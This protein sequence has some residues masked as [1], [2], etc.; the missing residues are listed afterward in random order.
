MDTLMSILHL[1]SLMI[2]NMCRLSIWKVIVNSNGFLAYAIF[3]FSGAVIFPISGCNSI[4][5]IPDFN[6][7]IAIRCDP[8]PGTC[9]VV[10]VT[11]APGAPVRTAAIILKAPNEAALH[12][13][14]KRLREKEALL[15]S[16]PTNQPRNLLE[17]ATYLS[18]L[19][20]NVLPASDHSA[21]LQPRMV[22]ERCAYACYSIDRIMQQSGINAR[23]YSKM[24]VNDADGKV[25]GYAG[26]EE[27]NGVVDFMYRLKGRE[28]VFREE[29]ERYLTELFNQ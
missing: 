22:L 28:Y 26:Y 13:D 16:N 17:V 15:A 1:R 23:L 8:E 25:L 29:T 5:T 6:P 9:M 3:A 21:Q 18:A 2:E 7:N 14:I 4:G 20:F 12:A 24:H 10:R 27:R 19:V 11:F